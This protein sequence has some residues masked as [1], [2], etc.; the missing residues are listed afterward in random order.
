MVGNYVFDEKTGKKYYYGEAT[1]DGWMLGEIPKDY[2]NV[3]PEFIKV[4]LLV[5]E[6]NASE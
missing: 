6:E 5:K 2:L 1:S 4:E 3:S